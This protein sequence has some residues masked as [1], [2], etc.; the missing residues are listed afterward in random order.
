[1]YRPLCMLWT[2]LGMCLGSETASV[3]VAAVSAKLRTTTHV[4]QHDHLILTCLPACTCISHCS[5]VN[6]LYA[7][8]LAWQARIVNVLHASFRSFRYCD[9]LL[10][11]LSRTGCIFVETKDQWARDDPA[12]L[13]LLSFWLLGKL[14]CLSA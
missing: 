12:F 8:Q 14:N 10:F 3:P 9:F 6:C 2:Y 7:A 13:V 4:P 1:V 11:V 5:V